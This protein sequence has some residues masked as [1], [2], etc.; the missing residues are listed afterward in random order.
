MR[1]NLKHS[2]SRD[3]LL[4]GVRGTRKLRYDSSSTTQTRALDVG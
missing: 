3:D 1:S 2:T 4:A